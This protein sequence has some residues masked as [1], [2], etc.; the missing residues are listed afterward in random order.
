MTT[1]MP[2]DYVRNLLRW[3]LSRHPRA[4]GLYSSDA[5][6]RAA[7]DQAVLILE[8]VTEEIAPIMTVMQVEHALRGTLDRLIGDHVLDK[9][10]QLV[11][12]ATASLIAAR[13][14]THP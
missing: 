10:D 3:H 5:M 7:V 12:I 13:Q 11:K 14:E 1:L 9:Q 4:Q 8:A 2:P 6:F